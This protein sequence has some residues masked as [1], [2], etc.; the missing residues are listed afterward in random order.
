MAIYRV[1][2][3]WF[4]SAD[5]MTSKARALAA[6]RVAELDIRQARLGPDDVAALVRTANTTNTRFRIHCT[7]DQTPEPLPSSDGRVEIEYH[8]AATAYPA[9][10]A[11]VPSG[12]GVRLTVT[13]SPHV[14]VPALPA[15]HK[16]VRLELAA[17]PH[18]S[19]VEAVG[20]TRDMAGG[21][22]DLV[23]R[24]S[25]NGCDV[26]IRGALPFCAFTD[27]EQ[28][29]LAREC[30]AAED[31]RSPEIVFSYRSD[32]S[33]S[34]WRGHLENLLVE[35]GEDRAMRN[36]FRARQRACSG[37]P[38]F[39]QCNGCALR[40]NG[41]C[42]AWD[43]LAPPYPRVPRQAIVVA[44]R[45]AERPAGI[46]LTR[47]P[48]AHVAPEGNAYRLHIPTDRTLPAMLLN[49]SALFVWE[50]IGEGI[51]AADLCTSVRQ[52]DDSLVMPVMKLVEQMQ[53]LGFVLADEGDLA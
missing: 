22:I 6:A 41:V 49:E 28:G 44:S 36:F 2:D 50:T 52:T 43:D 5:A 48:D 38:A 12:A 46:R 23:R 27:A 32:G 20:G 16:V 4:E 31:Y 9:D 14:A 11:S 53:R 24:L 18:A 17:S 35:P 19:D 7:I 33:V 34:P 47:H 42:A 1:V 45:L 29:V 25:R 39:A 26:G 3:G 51:D 30:L 21:M 10:W 13:L 37:G 15:L 8:V 40:K